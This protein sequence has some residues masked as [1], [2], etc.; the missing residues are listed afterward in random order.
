MWKHK[1]L[2]SSTLCSQCQLNTLEKVILYNYLVLAETSDTDKSLD[3]TWL[4][5]RHIVAAEENHSLQ[6]LL[7][8]ITGKYRDLVFITTLTLYWKSNHSFVVWQ[9]LCEMLVLSMMTGHLVLL[10]LSFLADPGCYQ[11]GTWLSKRSLQRWRL[12]L[13]TSPSI[14]F[15]AVT[16]MHY[17]LSY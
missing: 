11:T 15:L 14:C 2:I 7:V 8:I 12:A 6:G 13:P 10:K 4:S 16:M 9:K 17:F 3:S 5:W 1:A